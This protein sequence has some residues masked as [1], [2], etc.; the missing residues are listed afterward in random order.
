MKDITSRADIELLINTFY[1]K[2]RADQLIGPIFNDIANVD[3]PHHLPI[4]YDFW[5]SMLLDTGVYTR[6]AM[7][8]HFRLN[9]K[10]P[11]LPEHFARWI[12]IFESTVQQ[13]FEGDK[14][15][16][17]ITRARSIKGIMELKMGKINEDKRH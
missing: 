12:S 1:E 14:A 5:E 10:V 8:P 13:L 3:W 6:N 17:A 9:E 2:V 7:E 16:L 4:M 15:S 11:L